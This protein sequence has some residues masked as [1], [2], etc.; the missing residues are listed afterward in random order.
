VFG[1]DE[2]AGA[3]DLLHLRD[4][5]QRQRGLAR[6]LGAVDLDHAAARQP[7]DAERD[8]EPE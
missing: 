7:A 6:R 3:A 2:G 8:V 1:V 4:D 5:L